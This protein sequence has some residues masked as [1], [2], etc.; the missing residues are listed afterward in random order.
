MIIF[1]ADMFADQYGGGAELTT[2]ALIQGS[3]LPCKKILSS[4][5]TT[6]LMQQYSGCFWVFANFDHVSHECLFFAAK[7]LQY[8]VLEYDY[9]FCELRSPE[10]HIE[11]QGSCDCSTKKKG[12]LVSIFLN[13]AKVVWWMS[14]NQKNK[15]LQTFPFLKEANNKVLSSVLSE[16]TLNYIASL[17]I[18]S[19]NNK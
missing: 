14:H 2:E 15:Y 4:T 8:S 3:L 13:N 17:D 11:L 16:E 19:K 1:V 18:S 9:K 12:K 6:T 10:K 5:L 7:N